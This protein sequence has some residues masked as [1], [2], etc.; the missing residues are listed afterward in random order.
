MS[1]FPD[2][3]VLCTQLIREAGLTPPPT[4]LEAVSSLWPGL[5]VSEED[6]DKEGYLIFLGVQGAELMLRRADPPNRKRFTFAHELGH[7]ALSNMQDGKL[8]FDKTIQV[9]RSN[10]SSRQTPEERWCNEFAGKLLMPTTE[11]HRYLRGNVENVPK[12]L[13]TG[14][15]IFH[16]SEDAFLDRITD[17][18]GWIIVYLI[19]GRALH[20]IGRQFMRRNEDRK[21]AD[22]LVRDLLGQTRS[23]VRFPNNQIRLPG[24]TAYGALRGTTRETCS[25][26][27]C[28]MA[29][30]ANGIVEPIIRNP[31]E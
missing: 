19:H 8:L 4:D 18:T 5:K 30:D 28:L 22:E 29:E 3:N 12:K 9:A 2:A 20:K 27:I 13:V 10:H 6:L 25:Y 15:T 14:H 23:M 11:V 26:L 21:S 31:L 1:R 17:I 7:W 16:V 24:F